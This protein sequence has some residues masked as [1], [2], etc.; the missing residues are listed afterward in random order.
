MPQARRDRLVPLLGANNAVKKSGVLPLEFVTIRTILSSGTNGAP[1]P[2]QE[3]SFERLAY[4]FPFALAMDF[5][6]DFFS[7]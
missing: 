6:T 3:V 1:H 2:V 4:G 7:L 5:L